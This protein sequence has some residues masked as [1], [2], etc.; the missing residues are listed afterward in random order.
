MLGESRLMRC[1][2]AG[3]RFRAH[4]VVLIHRTCDKTRAYCTRRFRKWFVL[5]QRHAGLEL[6]SPPTGRNFELMRLLINYE[7]PL[8]IYS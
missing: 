1:G 3:W 2:I 8:D 6:T 7:Y 4:V 5:E